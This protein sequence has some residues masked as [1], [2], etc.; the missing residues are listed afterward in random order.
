[1]SYEDNVLACFVGLA[2]VLNLAVWAII[3]KRFR[4][5]TG[6]GKLP[7]L[8]VWRLLEK[9]IL[10]GGIVLWLVFSNS[11]VGIVGMGLF[12]IGILSAIASGILSLVQLIRGKRSSAPTSETP[13]LP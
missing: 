10:L 8:L 12:A 6:D 5:E 9:T 11:W 3:L 1:M 2:L 7:R 13:Q 4:S